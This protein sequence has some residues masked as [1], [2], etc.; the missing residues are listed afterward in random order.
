MKKQKKRLRIRGLKK[1]TE[2]RPIV[3]R[4][5]GAYGSADDVE[6]MCD[7]EK[8]PGRAVSAEVLKDGWSSI[9]HAG[10]GLL[11][12]TY[13]TNLVRA[14]AWDAWTGRDKDSAHKAERDVPFVTDWAEV[15]PLQ[16]IA[17]KFRRRFRAVGGE[18]VECSLRNPQYLG[19][20]IKSDRKSV[21][22]FAEKISKMMKLP[23]F[24]CRDFQ[25]KKKGGK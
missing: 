23:V 9:A 7:F 12:N 15:L 22:D 6:T 11:V 4:W 14:Y 5:L 21:R 20:I 2:Q 13:D 1:N 3:V 18:Y 17:G 24:H 19:I 16:K 25:K 10:V 8:D